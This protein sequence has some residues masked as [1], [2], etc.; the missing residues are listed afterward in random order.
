MP[1][2]RQRDLAKVRCNLQAQDT[3]RTQN[4]LCQSSCSLRKV[5]HSHVFTDLRPAR[6][7]SAALGALF[8]V[9]G[10]RDP[11]R[12]LVPA[13]GANANPARTGGLSTA[14]PSRPASA[15]ASSPITAAAS[16]ST[17][18]THLTHLLSSSA[19]FTSPADG[20]ALDVRLCRA[21]R[22]QPQAIHCRQCVV[23]AQAVAS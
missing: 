19:S 23:S 3:S 5:S 7:L 16:T 15:T 9:T 22:F 2:P 18:S 12:L 17:T 10:H 21:V 6:H 1:S 14:H 11:V 4:C 13:S 8:L 20:C